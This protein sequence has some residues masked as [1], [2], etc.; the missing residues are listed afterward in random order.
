[1]PKPKTY[2]VGNTQAID[3]CINDHAGIKFE[4]SDASNLMYLLRL[5]RKRGEMVDGLRR[6]AVT[7]GTVI[8][9]KRRA[10]FCKKWLA[11]ISRSVYGV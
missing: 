11:R 5:M 9:P 4:H 2:F 10:A 7:P 6:M 1:M 8:N 3:F